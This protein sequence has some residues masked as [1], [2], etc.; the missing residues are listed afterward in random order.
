MSAEPAVEHPPA[1]YRRER[2]RHRGGR[3]AVRSPGRARRRT[4]APEPEGRARPRARHRR[5]VGLPVERRRR[6]HR[7][8]VAPGH[9]H[10]RRRQRHRGHRRPAAAGHELV[11]QDRARAAT[12]AAG[13]ASSTSTAWSTATSCSS[14]PSGPPPARSSSSR[15]SCTPGAWC[16]AA[17]TCTSPAPGAGC[18]AAWS[19]T[20]SA[21]DSTEDAFGYRY[22]LPVRFAYDAAASEGVELMRY[23]FLSLDRGTEPPQLVAGEYGL[24]EMTRR[25]VRYPLDPETM[26]P[27]HRRGRHLAT[28]LARRAR[29]RPHAGRR[30]RRRHLLRD[31]QPR[32][33][34][35]RAGCTSG[36]PAGSGRFPRALPV[37]PE[38]ISYWPSTDRLWSLSEYPGRRFVFAMER[39]AA[40]VDAGPGQGA[41]LA[42]G[43]G[44]ARRSPGRTCSPRRRAGLRRDHRLVGRRLGRRDRSSPRRRHGA[45]GQLRGRRRV[46]SR[47]RGLGRRGLCR[48]LGCGRVGGPAAGVSSTGV[49][50][51][52]GVGAAVDGGRTRASWTACRR[53]AEG[54]DGAVV[55]GEA[56]PGD[57]VADGGRSGRARGR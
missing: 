13:S 11:L 1:A 45:L 38:D 22:V 50:V 39:S 35:P 18:S 48:R 2:G 15:C 47:W 49:P 28:G 51:G 32:A 21:C 57:G 53:A 46:G 4:R 10:L 24:A 44:P 40:P 17:P 7:A 6:G 12:S 26:P 29:A 30:G 52:G 56:G 9:H 3:R 43:P 42:T 14:C 37:G 41:G 54:A 31:L 5:R 25:L 36:S 19:T 27:G 8:L 33:L 16:G 20:S 55:D 34:P 23:S